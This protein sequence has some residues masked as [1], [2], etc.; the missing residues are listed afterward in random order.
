MFSSPQQE[1]L[2]RNYRSTRSCG[3]SRKGLLNDLEFFLL[4]SKRMLNRFLRKPWRRLSK[5]YVRQLRH[6]FGIA[7]R[8][9]ASSETG[10][11]KYIP[12]K[13]PSNATVAGHIAIL[14]SP[15]T[16]KDQQFR[17]SFRKFCQ[18]THGE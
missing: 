13:T 18:Q 3:R 7:R 12:E 4:D 1:S 11:L 15:V 16:A 6:S 9:L 2:H 5:R 17:R 14:S 10:L 8:S